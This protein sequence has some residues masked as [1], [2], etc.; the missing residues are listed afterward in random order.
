MTHLR[1]VVSA[2]LL[3]LAVAII[4]GSAVQCDADAGHPE[5]IDAYYTDG[6]LF[7]SAESSDAYVWAWLSDGSDD[8][9]PG[10]PERVINGRV[11]AS[12]PATIS[13][14]RYTLYLR[15]ATDSQRI[16]SVEIT[17]VNNPFT[18]DPSSISIGVG[19]TVKLKAEDAVRWTADN[20][21]VSISYDS[22]GSTVTGKEQGKAIVQAWQRNNLA[23]GVCEVAVGGELSIKPQETSVALYPGDTRSVQVI[24]NGLNSADIH[25]SSDKS[26]IVSVSNKITNGTITLKA[27]SLGST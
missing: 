20:D 19:K 4:A 27:E 2:A 16:D 8:L 23:C 22:K 15:D 7:Y 12:F 3:M 25:V 9:K 17:V 5:I 10:A 1:G 11:N 18:V 21:V 14:G 13:E 26:S 24:L 6:Q